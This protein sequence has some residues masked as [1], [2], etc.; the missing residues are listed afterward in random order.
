MNVNIILGVLSMSIMWRWDAHAIPSLIQRMRL[1][2][3]MELSKRLD[4][5]RQLML[6]LEF[7]SDD[8]YQM[9][10]QKLMNVLTKLRDVSNED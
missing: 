1:M 5:A 8:T 2:L 3:Q 4:Y 10:Y 6:R 7:A 9:T